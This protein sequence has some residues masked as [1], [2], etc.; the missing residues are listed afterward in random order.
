MTGMYRSVGVYLFLML[1]IAGPAMAGDA[2]VATGDDIVVYGHDIDIMRDVYGPSGF[3]T[4]PKEYV[5]AML[6]VRL[7][8]KEA[9]AVKLAGPVMPDEA[10]A[11]SAQQGLSMDR[12]KKLIQLYNQYV[13][14]IYDRYPVS[15]A[16]IESYYLAFPE[17]T[18]R[19]GEAGVANDFFRPDTLDAEMKKMIRERLIQ[20]RK[21]GLVADEF[22]RLFDKYYVKLLPGY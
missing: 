6:R 9:Q 11:Q 10:D 14:Y 7:F 3:E 4:T 5:D 22:K 15:D 20:N 17:K 19:E 12:F 8:A 1:M 18:T 2:I 13:V 16:A 21:P